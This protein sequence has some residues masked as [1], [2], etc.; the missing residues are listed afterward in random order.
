M[1]LW[2]IKTN[3]CVNTFDG[4]EDKLWAVVVGSDE[5]QIVTGGSDSKINI[6]KDVTELEAEEELRITE[7]RILQFVDH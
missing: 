2:T 6:W 1:K 3:E 5:T 4:H 7:A